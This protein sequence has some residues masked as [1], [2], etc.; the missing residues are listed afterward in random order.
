MRHTSGELTY[1]FKLGGLQDF[2]LEATEINREGTELY[3]LVPRNQ[4]SKIATL[5]FD[6]VTVANPGGRQDGENAP[7]SVRATAARLLR[8]DP[9]APAVRL[10]YRDGW[11]TRESARP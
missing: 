5:R 10:V 7:R 4:M 3:A 2:A 1:G 8:P 11:F 9:D 6:S